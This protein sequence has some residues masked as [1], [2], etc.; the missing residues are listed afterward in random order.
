M[1]RKRPA[2]HPDPPEDIDGEALLEWHRIVDELDS[3]G[4]LA[5][6]DRALLTIYVETWAAHRI[7]ARRVASEGA[8]KEYINGNDGPS[9]YFKVMKETAVQLRR[10]L[11]D[12]MLTP[13]SRRSTEGAVEMEDLDI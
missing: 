7:A 1:R 6:T 11:K 10:I 3:Q 8:V 9:P 5:R 13:S 12:L 4:A 2:H